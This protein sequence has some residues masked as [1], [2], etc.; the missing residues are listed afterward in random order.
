[1]ANL[2]SDPEKIQ[3]WLKYYNVLIIDECSMIS[4]E[5]KNAIIDTYKGCKI[6]FCGDPITRSS[7]SDNGCLGFLP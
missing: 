1:M 2:L 7:V 5:R 4:N 3:Y 6:I